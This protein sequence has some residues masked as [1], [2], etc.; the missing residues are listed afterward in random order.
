M[1]GGA[2]HPFQGGRGSPPFVLLLQHNIQKTNEL[3]RV[4]EEDRSPGT[5]GRHSPFLG[6]CELCVTSSDDR[7]AHK[8]EKSAPQVGEQLGPELK[9]V[10]CP[11]A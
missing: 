11:A 6:F 7:L 10:A 3:G 5:Q 9:L 8:T 2:L 1:E 4:V